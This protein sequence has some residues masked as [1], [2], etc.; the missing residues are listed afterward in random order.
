MIQ[1][2]FSYFEN[3][4]PLHYKMHYSNQ[5]QYV[6]LYPGLQFREADS[7]LLPLAGT[8]LFL[9]T[10]QRTEDGHTH[11]LQ[12]RDNELKQAVNGP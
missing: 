10:K 8:K 5:N 9:H 1:I 2:S 6:I 4:L 11:D 12:W 3:Y 7:H